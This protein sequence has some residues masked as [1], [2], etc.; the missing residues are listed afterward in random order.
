VRVF[1]ALAALAGVEH[2]LGEIV[3]GREAPPAVV[4]ESWPDAAA[5]EP[6]DGEPAMS[7]VP[8][9]LVSGVLSVLIALALGVVAVLHPRRRRSGPL[10]VGLSVCLLLVGGGFG[11]PLLG[12]LAG[13]L[14]TRAHAPPPDHGPG[15]GPVTRAGA[16]LWPWPLVAAAGCFLGLVPGTALLH[17]VTGTVGSTL[18]ALLT[19]GAFAATA[20]AVWT[21][22]ARD[23]L[24]TM[25]RHRP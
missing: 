25:A 2:G 15:P 17:V 21:A 20:L 18:V 16:G 24:G 6:L 7:L 4:F 23:R 22:R 13:L 14:A 1:G 10:L 11:P 19:V 9:L 12:V 5:F 8:D 3:Q